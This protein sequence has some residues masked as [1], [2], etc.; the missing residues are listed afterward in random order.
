MHYSLIYPIRGHCLGGKSMIC[1]SS[2]GT[3]HQFCKPLFQRLM[4]GV[5]A[6]SSSGPETKGNEETKQCS[7]FRVVWWLGAQPYYSIMVTASCILVPG[8][9]SLRRRVGH[10][11]PD[12]IGIW[13]VGWGYRNRNPAKGSNDVQGFS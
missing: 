4:I 12:S 13:I 2:P 6:V 11:S 3:C 5:W 7:T 9:Q 8:R 10:R 1:P